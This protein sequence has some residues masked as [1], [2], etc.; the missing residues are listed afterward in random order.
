MMQRFK[1]L[2]ETQNEMKNIFW[3]TATNVAIVNLV[4]LQGVL[5]D[6]FKMKYHMIILPI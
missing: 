3:N 2:N 5:G 6:S 4:P 1:V